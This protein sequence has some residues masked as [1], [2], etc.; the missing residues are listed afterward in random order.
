MK[1]VKLYSAFCLA[2]LLGGMTCVMPITV[3]AKGGS[4]HSG[5]SHAGNHNSSKSVHVEGYTRRDG[6]YVAPYTRSAPS[7]GAHSSSSSG[8]TDNSN[9]SSDLTKS[10]SENNRTNSNLKSD[11]TTSNPEISVTTDVPQSEAIIGKPKIKELSN[12]LYY[13]YM[14]RGYSQTAQKDYMSAL[15]SFEIALEERPGDAYA[16]KAIANVKNYIQGSPKLQVD[17]K[18]IA[19]AGILL[20]GSFISL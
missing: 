13:E 12:N 15:T 5:S 14:K 9:S 18:L 3:W 4:G 7:S 16:T 10:D 11:F 8:Y 6:T 17:I 1:I 19:S 20:H 2:T